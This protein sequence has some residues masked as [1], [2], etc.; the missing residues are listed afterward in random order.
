MHSLQTIRAMNAEAG[1]ATRARRTRARRVRDIDDLHGIPFLG[2]ACEDIDATH[3]R[4]DTLFCDISGFGRPDEPA[5]TL[6]QFQA[7][8]QEFLDEDTTRPLLVAIEEHGQ[9]QAHVAIW[10]V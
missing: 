8:V 1:A 6:K 5:L 2:D 9:F 4:L 10:E 3:K 7:K